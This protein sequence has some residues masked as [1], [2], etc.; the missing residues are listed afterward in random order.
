MNTGRVSLGGK[1]P[2][3]F[4][5]DDPRGRMQSK[6]KKIN[7]KMQKEQKTLDSRI[8]SLL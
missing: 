1:E 5:I 3:L 4:A 7:K 8:K 2:S 6:M